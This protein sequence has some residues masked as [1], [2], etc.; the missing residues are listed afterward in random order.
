[1]VK[2]LKFGATWCGPCRIL[3]ETIKNIDLPI[4]SY[5][6]DEDEELAAKYD[7][8]SVP[9]LIYVDDEGKEIDRLLGAVTKETIINKYEELNV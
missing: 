2:I 8:L 5:D 1:M 7:I 9:A 6:V 3:T 4:T